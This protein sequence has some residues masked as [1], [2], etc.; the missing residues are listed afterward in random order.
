MIFGALLLLGTAKAETV[1][2]SSYNLNAHGVAATDYGLKDDSGNLV[3]EN[4]ISDEKE[5]VSAPA[6]WIV[7]I[8]VTI[9]IIGAVFGYWYIISGN[10]KENGTNDSE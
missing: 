6:G 2:Y 9:A 4:E 7:A 8:I 10:N 1:T 3:K 5:S